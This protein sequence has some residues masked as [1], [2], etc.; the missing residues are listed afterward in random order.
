M[1]GKTILGMTAV[2]LGHL[3]IAGHLGQ[4]RGGADGGHQAIALDHGARFH[5]QC[6]AA[7]A[8]DKDQLGGDLQS[9]HGALHRQ[10]GGMQDVELV[11]LL[12]SGAT[13]GPGERFLFDLV[14][15]GEAL[16]LGELLGIVEPRDRIGGIENDRSGD[17]VTHQGATAHFVHTGNQLV[18]RNIDHHLVALN[19]NRPRGA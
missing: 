16:L 7:V 19:Q 4:N 6:R 17:H 10:H 18:V 9:R 2:Q 15:Q 8:I 13:D 11:D 3:R 5:R 1:A 14:K 12:R